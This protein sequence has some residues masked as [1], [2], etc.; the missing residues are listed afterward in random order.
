MRALSRMTLASFALACAIACD[1]PPRAEPRPAP[2]A[3]AP[4]ARCE[5][6]EPAVALEDVTERA[7]IAL[8]ADAGG[9]LLAVASGDALATRALDAE[10]RPTSAPRRAALEGVDGLLALEPI[11]ARTILV[12]RGACAE[13][14]YCLVALDVRGA[15]GAPLASP[16]PAPVRTVRRAATDRALFVAWSTSTGHR[17]IE[18]FTIEG[19]SL[20]RARLPLGV[21]PASEEAPVEILGL[22]TDGDRWA[23]VWRRGPTED[24][25]SAVFVTSND[26]HDRVDALH[27]A[28]A[29]DSIALSGETLE[30][31]ATFEFSRPHYLRLRLGRLEPE[32]ARELARGDAASAAF[33]DRERA[34]LDADARGLWLARRDAAGDPIGERVRVVDGAVRSAALARLGDSLLLAWQSD[35]SVWTRRVAC[36]RA[37]ATE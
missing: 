21:E 26:H 11:G 36:Q 1:E 14:A 13:S 5:L 18:R 37:R 20:G 27:D 31:V 17:G 30:L 3:P 16:L 15:I 25:R 33:A 22:A 19:D 28:L 7:S 32:L 8:A 6:S 9:A 24:V 34:E 4:P 10:G 35:R 23:A 2:R 29:I 12:A